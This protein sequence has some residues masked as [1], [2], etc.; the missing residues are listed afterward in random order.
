VKFTA[1]ILLLALAPIA[2]AHETAEK[3]PHPGFR[4][5]CESDAAFVAEIKT[6]DMRVYP[7]II[8][9]PTNT[10]FSSESQQQI[11]VFLNDNKVTTATS[12]SSKIDPGKLKGAAQFDWFMNDMAVIG[13]AIK[14]RAVDEDYI[15]VMEVLFPPMHGNRQAVF[16][17]HCIILDAEGENAFSFL[18]NSH[19]QMFVDADLVVDDLSEKSRAE[20]V[21]KATGVGLEALVGQIRLE[22]LS[23]DEYRSRR[24]PLNVNRS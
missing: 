18:L 3:S 24:L 4:P 23:Q 5:E 13:K 11:V 6:A 2:Q 15:L 16:G 7:T 21:S 9:T 19:H 8:R 1:I 14:S 12:D 10:Y 22:T 17:I 20:L